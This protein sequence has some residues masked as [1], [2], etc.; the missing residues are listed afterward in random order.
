MLAAPLQLGCDLTQLDAFTRALVT[1]DEILE[2]D[3]D[4]L[5][6][7]AECEEH[8]DAH[9]V[10][11]RTL[12][13]GSLAVA[14][15]NRFFT[16]RTFDFPLIRHGIGEGWRVRCVWAQKDLGIIG[17]ADRNWKVR[18]VPPHATMI[19]RFY[20]PKTWEKPVVPNGDC[21]DCP[22]GAR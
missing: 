2:I 19:L 3:L 1:N 20:P 8:D 5:G 4:E 11:V 16:D 7:P 18:D 14:F 10:W 15:F 6:R 13:D 12:C 22:K 17:A 21:P 9:D